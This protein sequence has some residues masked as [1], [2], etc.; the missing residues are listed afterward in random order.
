M[1]TGVPPFNASST[2]EIL[3]KVLDQEPVPPRKMDPA[4]PIDLQTIVMKCL[5]KTPE[6]RYQSARSLS[7]DLSRF[8]DG[9]PILARRATL[10]Y[11]LNKKIRKNPLV[12]AL[13]AVA[14]IAVIIFA[15][16]AGVV[17]WRSKEQAKLFQE[18]GQ[19]VTRI[20]AIMRYGY[21]LPLHDV[22]QEKSQVTQRLDG[23]TKRMEMLGSMAYGPGNYSL[24]RGYL[25]LHRYQD[26]YDHLIQAWQKYNYRESEVANS[27]GL[28]LAMLYQEK[29]SDAEHTYSKD[30]LKEKKV[31]LQKQ[32]RD[33][34]LQ[35]I[36]HSTTE[37]PEYVD[38]VIAYLEQKYPEALKKSEA[39]T[40]KA[41]WL[42]EGLLLHGNIFTA[43][44][45]DQFAMGK[46]DAASEFYDKARNAYLAAAKKGQSDPQ[47]YEGL[48]SLQYKI[49]D[50]M[51]QQ[52]GTC[53]ASI[54]EEGISYC[55][56]ALQADSKNI[57]GNLLAADIYKLIAYE[58]TIS[59]KDDSASVKNAVDFANA[60]LKIDPQNSSAFRRLG[61]IYSTQ[62]SMEIY[63]GKNPEPFLNLANLNFEKAR[64]NIP[65]DFELIS[66][67]GN[68][69]VT[70]ARYEVELGKDP[71]QTLETAMIS[72]RKALEKN[73]KNFRSY[74]NLGTA[75]YTKGT[76]EYDAGLDPRKS[77]E[78]A[79]RLFKKSSEINPTYSNPYEYVGV[80]NLSLGTYLSDLGADAIPVLDD[81]ISAY[82]KCLALAPDD[83]FSYFGI[84]T[85]YMTK[86]DILQRAGKDPSAELTASRDAFK[87]SL[88]ANNQIVQTY[89]YFAETEFIAARDAMAHQKSPESFLME[90]E[91][92]LNDGEK[93]SL[94]CVDCINSVVSLHQLRAQ[95][96]VSKQRPAEA[97]IRA[98]LE[99]ANNA[100]K[101]R[102]STANLYALRGQLYLTQA[103]SSSGPDRIKAA[104]QAKDSF[105]HAFKIKP[106]LKNRYMKS[107]QEVQG[108][109]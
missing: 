77:L 94:D 61:Q 89:A 86:A 105:D 41:G 24:G 33:L 67:I 15:A 69:F 40:Q 20:E 88:K 98:G 42:Y 48:C 71:R 99:I 66:L 16:I 26:A 18:F 55:Q 10:S 7:E 45:D 62:A 4:I 21:L 1:I 49:Q 8:L 96:F 91:R 79:I 101:Q 14:V 63:A 97:H 17:Q 95:Y 80:A 83:A 50:M 47:I 54:P 52:K 53:P 65:E 78:E 22:Q 104:Q 11:R 102:P 92:I 25:S 29:L 28:S 59:G 6:R 19:E 72:L 5:E 84:A 90:A 36:R 74:S 109:I 60:A 56:K 107:W 93:I 108:F 32:Y 37:S 27:L 103:H 39:V 68:N 43:M 51:I 57:T 2:T 73:P 30:Q 13:I 81:S 106:L 100:L 76:Y 58:Q 46:N 23:I 35:Y 34:A 70:Q 75:Y 38:A 85:S 64:K 12:S 87:K 9:D 31:E 3:M 82:S 44:G